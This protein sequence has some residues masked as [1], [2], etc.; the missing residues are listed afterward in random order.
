MFH[1]SHPSCYSCYKPGDRSCIDV[2]LV[3]LRLRLRLTT[4]SETVPF[5]TF[6]AM[7]Y[8]PK[9][10]AKEINISGPHLC[11]TCHRVCNKSNT[12]GVTCGTWT[13]YLSG[14]PEFILGFNELRIFCVAC[15]FSFSH[16]IVCPFLIYGIWLLH[17][18]FLTF[19]ARCTI[20]F[21][22]VLTLHPDIPLQN[23]F[24]L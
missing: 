6:V 18:Y 21:V 15:S 17:W 8:L 20:M 4:F 22:L 2:F 5:I 1:M 11:M 16:C 24:G 12:T 13:T 19:F 9:I 3:H 10:H 14:A 7:P 23:I